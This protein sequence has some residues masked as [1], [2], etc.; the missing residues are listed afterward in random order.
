[1]AAIDR[2]L[3]AEIARDGY[4]VL[5]RRTS[6]T[7]AQNVDR[8]EDGARGVSA[9]A[10]VMS[11]LAKRRRDAERVG[12]SRRLGVSLTQ[13]FMSP[14]P[15]RSSA[16]AGR[17]RRRRDARRAGV[18]VALYEAAPVLGGR[19]RRVVRDGFALDNGQH[20]LLG[21]YRE[22]LALAARACTALVPFVRRSLS[23]GPS[24]G[25]RAGRSASTVPPAP[26]DSGCCSAC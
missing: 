18:A 9:V 24:R 19:A 8:V 26:G 7:P 14:R 10:R 16:A 6:L 15:S 22:T 3:L 1:M 21:A 11:S 12:V 5:D 13:P 17:M 25:E 23:A 2:R 20:L 4:Q